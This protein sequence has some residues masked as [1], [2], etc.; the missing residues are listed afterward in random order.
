MVESN[1]T[2]YI[3]NGFLL[4]SSRRR[5]TRREMRANRKCWRRWNFPETDTWTPCLCYWR[6]WCRRSW[7]PC[8]AWSR[9]CRWGNATS[10]CST[11]LDSAPPPVPR[12]RCCPAKSRVLVRS[13]SRWSKWFFSMA[14]SRSEKIIIESCGH[15][16]DRQQNQIPFLVEMG[17]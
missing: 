15:V 2:L 16:D 11:G 17:E 1:N 6:C 5:S 14:V 3:Q 4:V 13:R 9:R 10:S 12:W 8:V 7:R